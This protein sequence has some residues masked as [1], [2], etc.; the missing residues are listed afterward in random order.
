MNNS[1]LT[2]NITLWDCQS[3]YYFCDVRIWSGTDFSS[4]F[5][6]SVFLLFAVLTFSVIDPQFWYRFGII[7]FI[8]A[9]RHKAFWRQLSLSEVYPVCR[10][11]Q[12]FGIVSVSFWNDLSGLPFPSFFLL[13][14]NI[15]NGRVGG[16]S[17]IFLLCCVSFCSERWYLLKKQIIEGMGNRNPHQDPYL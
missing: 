11:K 3:V 7:L 4:L 8:F 9:H 15:T 5:S 2:G 6:A 12:R 17:G 13:R 10:T 14:S 1:T 16:S